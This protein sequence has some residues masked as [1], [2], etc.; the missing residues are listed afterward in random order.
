M[1]LVCT[2]KV[3]LRKYFESAWQINFLR[4]RIDIDLPYGYVDGLL[5]ETVLSLR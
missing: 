5:N 2:L 1:H 4:I 3:M